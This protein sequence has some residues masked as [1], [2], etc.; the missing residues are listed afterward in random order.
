M[1]TSRSSRIQLLFVFRAPTTLKVF[2][3]PGPLCSSGVQAPPL[4]RLLS[5]CLPCA[6]G[7]EAGFA[8][9]RSPHSLSVRLW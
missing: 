2:P 7:H 8:W 5:P 3:V 6:R 9:L 1:G 4:P